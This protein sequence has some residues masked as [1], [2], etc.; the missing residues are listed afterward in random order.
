MAGATQNLRETPQLGGCVFAAGEGRPEK[1]SGCRSSLAGAILS[2][3]FNFH[4]VLAGCKAR[5]I[6]CQRRQTSVRLQVCVHREHRFHNPGPCRGGIPSL[7]ARC[8][9]IRDAPPRRPID[10]PIDGASIDPNTCS[11][12]PVSF[13]SPLLTTPCTYMPS[14]SKIGEPLLLFQSKPEMR[15]WKVDEPPHNGMTKK[16]CNFS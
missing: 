11:T 9:S 12:M 14:R 1:M 16:D 4:D 3:H 5:V 7:P 13:S 2:L 15:W 8:N 10:N 6:G